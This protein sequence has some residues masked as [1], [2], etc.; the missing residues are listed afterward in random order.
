MKFV[1]LGVVMLSLGWLL[2]GCKGGQQKGDYFC[3]MHPQIVRENPGEKCP[4]CNMP[5]SKRS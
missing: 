4:I 2:A 3:P 5:L 1:R